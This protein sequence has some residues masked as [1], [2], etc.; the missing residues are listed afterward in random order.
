MISEIKGHMDARDAR[1]TIVMSEFNPLVTDQLLQGAVDA[2]L[3]RGGSQERLQIIRVPGAFEI[4]GTVAEYLRHNEPDAVV[5]LGAVI[6][7]GTPHFDYVAGQAADGIGRLSQTHNLPI[8]FGILTTNTLEQ[9]LERAGTKAGNKGW[10][11]MDAA[12]Q[13]ISVYQQM[14][15]AE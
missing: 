2:F 3:H 15:S 13:M 1:V 6:R 12:L 14:N 11:V 7:G 10:E 9:A 8:I 4:P 5:T